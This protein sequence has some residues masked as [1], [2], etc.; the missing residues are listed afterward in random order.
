M[1]LLGKSS[2]PGFSSCSSLLID[3]TP[4]SQKCRRPSCDF[5]DSHWGPRNEGVVTR[6]N[7]PRY[8]RA[9]SAP[10]SRLILCAILEQVVQRQRE[11]TALSMDQTPT[12]PDV[13]MSMEFDFSWVSLLWKPQ[14]GQSSPLSRRM[15]SFGSG[16]RSEHKCTN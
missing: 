10:L 4:E 13:E 6:L 7:L 8:G 16:S 12:E 15:H 14:V 3:S 1:H 9:A 11:L 5:G 2:G